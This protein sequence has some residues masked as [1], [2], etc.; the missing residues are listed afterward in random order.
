MYRSIGRLH[1]ACKLI[2]LNKLYAKEPLLAF[3]KAILVCSI[4]QN[5]I[6][7]HSNTGHLFLWFVSFGYL[8]SGYFTDYH[9]NLYFTDVKISV[10]HQ[11]G[12]MFLILLNLTTRYIKDL[13]LQANNAHK[14]LS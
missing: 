8:S 2:R 4:P 1:F 3:L 5:C 7:T 14:F 13:L 11:E 10:L 9:G 12:L 6:I